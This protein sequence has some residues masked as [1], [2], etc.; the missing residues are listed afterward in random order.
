MVKFLLGFHIHRFKG[1][2][3]KEEKQEAIIE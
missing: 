2:K 3:L 1:S